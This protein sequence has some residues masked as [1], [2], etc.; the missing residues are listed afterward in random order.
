MTK[1]VSYTKEI[2]VKYDVDLCVVGGGPAGLTAA[3]AAARQGISVYMAESH[4]FFGGAATAGMVP[5]FMPFSNGGEFL[6]G[7]LGREIYD[8]CIQKDFHSCDSWGTLGIVLEP[9]K[10]ILDDMVRAE[11]NI[12]FSFFTTLIDVKTEKS[13]VKQCIFTAK[14]GLFAVNAKIFVDGTGDGDLC[15]WAGA[16]YELGGPEEPLMP[17]TLCSLWDDVNWDDKDFHDIEKMEEAIKDGVFSQHDRHLPGMFR[18]GM[19]SNIGG[20]NIGHSFGIDSTDELS[21]T[22]GMLVGRTILPEYE[23]Y[24]R[25][26]LGR[27]YKNSKI[28]ATAP[29]LG[30]RESRR[31]IGDYVLTGD[32]FFAR[33]RFDDEIGVFSYPID[34]HPT[35]ATTDRF[36]KFAKEY[37]KLRYEPGEFYGIPYRILLPQTLENVYVVGRCASFDRKMQSSI[38]VMPGCFIMGQAAGVGAALAV[39]N[40]IATRKV[41]VQKLRE[42]LKNMGAYLPA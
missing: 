16:P 14:S 4:G 34:I 32:D 31:I 27:G 36:E 42:I 38:R 1:T 21:L 9:Y 17:S 40:G 26:Y 24:Y 6:A 23:K 25:Q 19:S 30:V 11:E 39:T 18:T 15:A 2:P 20:G 22:E 8:H 33:A 7:G 41:D 13:V 35:N 3:I 10:K 28:I 29:Y 12:K 37:F 5:A